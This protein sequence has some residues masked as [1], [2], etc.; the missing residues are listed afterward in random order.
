MSTPYLCTVKVVYFSLSRAQALVASWTKIPIYRHSQ[1]SRMGDKHSTQHL[2][3]V[4][5]TKTK[6]WSA[7][8]KKTTC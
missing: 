6:E 7:P 5:S 1:A 3:A 8:K 4:F 2:G